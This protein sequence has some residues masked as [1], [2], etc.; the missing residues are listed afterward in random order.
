MFELV[1]RFSFNKEI[2]LPYDY[3]YEFYSN[4]IKFDK[5][6]LNVIISSTHDIF[7]TKEEKDVIKE[8]YT[9]KEKYN[10]I[11]IIAYLK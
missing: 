2:Y 7:F 9:I 1:L 5:N 11:E 4:T 10:I 6:K 3:Y 8:F